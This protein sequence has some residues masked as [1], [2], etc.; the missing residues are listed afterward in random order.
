MNIDSKMPLFLLWID[1]KMIQKKIMIN[2]EL[3]GGSIEKNCSHACFEIKPMV[4]LY[5]SSILII[6][7]GKLKQK[8]YTLPCQPPSTLRS[9]MGKSY[10]YFTKMLDIKTFYEKI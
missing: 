3:N 2:S 6:I 1:G 8:H 4:D 9:S 10:V 5:S 7:S